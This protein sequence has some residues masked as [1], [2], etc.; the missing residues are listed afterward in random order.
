MGSVQVLKASSEDEV[1][2]LLKEDPYAKLG[3]WD[4]DRATVSLMKVGIMTPI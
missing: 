1:W 4:L 2:Q 3:V